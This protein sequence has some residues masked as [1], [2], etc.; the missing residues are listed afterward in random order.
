MKFGRWLRYKTLKLL[1]IKETPDLIAKGIAIGVSVDFLPTFGLGAIFAYFFATIFRVN[2]IAAVITSL[3]LKWLIIPFYAA[4]IMV[5]RV[6]LGRPTGE[7][8]LPEVTSFFSLQTVK[9]LSD[10]FLV[11]SVVNALCSGIV[12]Y[13][14][15][16]RI[17]INRRARRKHIYPKVENSKS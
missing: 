10:A 17:I 13:Y 8:Q 12:V 2:R 14:I 5:G 7:V 3:A 11:G 9:Q 15:S 4:N 1:R 16:R 6:I